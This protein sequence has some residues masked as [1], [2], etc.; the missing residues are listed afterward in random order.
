MHAIVITFDRLQRTFLGCYGNEWIETPNLDRFAAQGIV[1]HQHL[2]ENF[3]PQAAHHAWWTGCY[4]FPRSAQGQQALPAFTAPLRAAGVRSRLIVE[5]GGTVPLPPQPAF[6]EVVHVGGVSGLDAVPRETPFARAVTVALEAVK[7]LASE[8]RTPQLLWLKSA[9]LQPP[10]LAPRDFAELYR[11][12]L[13]ESVSDEQWQAFVQERMS[14]PR[15][16]PIA[17]DDL[18]ILSAVYAGAVTLVDVWLG[19]LLSAIDELLGQEV[20]VIVAGDRSERWYSAAHAPHECRASLCSELVQAP[21]LIRLPPPEECSGGHAQALLQSVDVA[22]TLWDWFGLPAASE[23]IEGCS[24]LP[25]LRGESRRVRE[26]AFVGDGGE[27]AGIRT[28]EWYL[29]AR[30]AGSVLADA[31]LFAKPDD[32]W[33]V[34]NLAPQSPETVEQL[35][36]RLGEFVALPR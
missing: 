20:L 33:D 3:A 6:D 21:L 18:P 2:G 24:W 11:D 12:E 34:N 10:W 14:R 28:D 25:L 8:R 9:G 35:L 1:C 23:G 13:E 4:Q 36:G 16:L 19:K 26:C 30:T 31:C 7:R 15:D 29:T 27:G 22:A 17:E 5:G 32:A